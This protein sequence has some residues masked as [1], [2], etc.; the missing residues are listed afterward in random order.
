MRILPT[1]T[2]YMK[3]R[4][5]NKESVEWFSNAAELGTIYDDF[6][7]VASRKD[8]ELNFLHGD[9]L[10]KWLTTRIP[11]D[12]LE[13]VCQPFVSHVKPPLLWSKI[14][15][16]EHPWQ[17]KWVVYSYQKMQRGRIQEIPKNHINGVTIKK[18]SNLDKTFL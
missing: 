15:L 16:K 2:V 3:P 6:L 5:N 18:R 8:M 17:L 9:G 10:N 4:L 12:C 14:Y 13:W 7:N 1:F 11:A